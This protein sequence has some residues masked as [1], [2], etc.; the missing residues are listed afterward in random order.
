VIILFLIQPGKFYFEEAG[1]S[2]CQPGQ[3][4]LQLLFAR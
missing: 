2:R 4:P 3:W 1:F